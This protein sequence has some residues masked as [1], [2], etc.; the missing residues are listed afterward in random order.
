M[1]F[2]GPKPKTFKTAPYY[3]SDPFISGLNLTVVDANTF[4]I[5]PGVARDLISDYAISFDPLSTGL[6][7]IT[8]DLRNTGPN[9]CFPVPMSTLLPTYNTVYCVYL[10]ANTAGTTTG[11]NNPLVNPAVVVATGNEFLPEGYDAYRRIG[12]IFVNGVNGPNTGPVGTINLW[13]QSGNGNERLYQLQTSRIRFSGAGATTYSPISLTSNPSGQAGIVPLR[14]GIF[15]TFTYRLAVGTAGDDIFFSTDGYDAITA[16]SPF[17]VLIG[18][19]TTTAQSEGNFSLL[20]QLNANGTDT[21]IFYKFS[22]A[23]GSIQVNN[24]GFVD[25]IGTSLI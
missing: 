11:S 14:N 24:T 18:N 20:S 4:T 15:C 16:P 17:V 22:G 13:I 19:T 23:G 9:G 5:S 2:F 12:Y 6:Q 10:I 7:N 25:S 1:A 21:Q 3:G 8:V